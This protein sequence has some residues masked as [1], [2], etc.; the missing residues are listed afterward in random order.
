MHAASY[1]FWRVKYFGGAL[2]C[3]GVSRIQ[4]LFILNVV[5]MPLRGEKMKRL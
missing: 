4:F 2:L 3:D 5:N 1:I